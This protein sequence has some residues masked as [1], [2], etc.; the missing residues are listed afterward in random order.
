[1]TTTATRIREA[2]TLLHLVPPMVA[3]E[4]HL[5]KVVRACAA[6][7]A[8]RGAF[9]VDTGGRVCGVITIDSLDRDLLMLLTADAGGNGERL[10]PRQLTRLAHGLDERARD[11]SREAATVGLDDTM[12][13][14]LRRMHEH[15]QECAAV[16]DEQGAL[17]GYVA[18]FELLAE[19]VVGTPRP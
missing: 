16:L 18:L 19:L 9:V 2:D 13:T 12:A 3:P 5:D 4:D 11:L 14:A 6:D 7:P 10:N 8:A 17:F 15:H 1:M